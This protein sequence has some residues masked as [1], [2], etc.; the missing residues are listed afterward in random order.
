MSELREFRLNVGCAGPR[1]ALPAMESGAGPL[2]PCGPH[3]IQFDDADKVTVGGYMEA[4]TQRRRLP[5]Q[6]AF[7]LTGFIQMLDEIGVNTAVSVEIFSDEQ[8]ARTL[9]DAAR[10]AHDT[11]LAL[12]ERAG[13]RRTDT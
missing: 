2:N 11:T 9:E 12:F 6:G 7:D 13:R 1:G 8:G 3:L 5:G 4:T 10:L